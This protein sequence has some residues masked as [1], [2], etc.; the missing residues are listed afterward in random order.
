MRKQPTS[1]V[2]L[3]CRF[4]PAVTYCFLAAVPLAAQESSGLTLHQAIA[5]AEQNSAD[6]KLARVQYQVALAA[7]SVA[8]ASFRPNLYTGSGAAYTHGFPSLP[9]GQAPAVFQLDYTQALFNPLLKGDQHAAEDRAKSQ[10]I[11]LDRVQDDVIVRTATAYLDL[12]KV[13]HSLELTRAEQAS[14][15]KILEIVHE[16]VA[17]NQELPIESTRGELAVARAQQRIV[18]LE[19]R[20]QWLTE[21]LR[22]LTGISDTQTIEPIDAEDASLASQLSTALAEN[23]MVNLALQN[24]RQLAEA[25]EERVAREQILHGARWSYFPTVDLVGQ[26]SLLS[27]FNNYDE[28]YKKFER[29]NVNVGLQITIPLFAAKTSS[30]VALAKTQLAESEATL[31]SRRQQVRADIQQKVRTVRELDANREVARLDLKLAQETLQLSQ[32]K[33]DQGRA[34]LQEVEQARLDENE[35]WIAYLDADFARERAQLVLLQA[36]GQLAQVFR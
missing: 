33:L 22:D 27:K 23:E 35:K 17:A 25:S 15:E 21:Q 32:A 26:Y 13:R 6:V 11:E 14:S 9:G 30:N 19:D 1:V 28:F 2:R 7:A 20:E 24:D 4:A 16:R 29:N 36:T 8:R 5:L 3:L 12:G 10:K 34:T 31:A 18:Q